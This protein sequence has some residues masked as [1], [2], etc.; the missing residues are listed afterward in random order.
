VNSR[1]AIANIQVIMRDLHVTSPMMTGADVADVQRR[2]AACGYQI[3]ALD[4]NYGP[5]TAAAIRALQKDHGLTVDGVVGPRTRAA[6]EAAVGGAQP[7]P[8]Q[9]GVA[10]LAEA[11][12]H[13]GVKEHP[14]QSNQTPFGVWFGVDGVAWCN[15]FV[16][17]C[18]AKGGDY[19]ICNNFTGAGIREGKGC[20]YVPTT[21][22]WLRAT[23][24]WLGRVPPLPG[25]IAIY[26]WDG[27]EADHIG[28]VSR[29]LGND[30]FEAIEGN[31]AIGSDSDG[32]EVMRRVRNL[33]QVNGFGRVAG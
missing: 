32:G 31:T 24:M 22:A 15:I 11:I 12:K 7:Q 8:S 29:Y 27:N 16:S 3:G 21:E 28:I 13:I 18:F 19:I 10:A 25:D 26:N 6:L 20:T 33:K 17:Y 23:G 5:A 14:P 4:G 2:L 9:P 30:D 1:Y